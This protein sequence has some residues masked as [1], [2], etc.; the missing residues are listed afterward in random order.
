MVSPSLH[1][2]TRYLLAAGGAIN[3]D[4]V[5]AYLLYVEDDCL[6]LKHWTGTQFGDEETIAEDIRPGSTASYVVNGT[7]RTIV[8]ISSTN[9]I[10][11]WKYHEEDEEWV[12]DESIPA[13]TVH[14]NSHITAGV[15]AEQ[16]LR[17]AFQGPTGRL[18][19]LD[20]KWAQTALPANPIIGT[21]LFTVLW[22]GSFEVCYVSN[23]TRIHMVSNNSDKVMI[24]HALTENLKRMVILPNQSDELEVF[25]LTE[26]D[27][28]LR[29]A[30]EGGMGMSKEV[31]V[32]L[33]GRFIE[34]KV[35]GNVFSLAHRILNM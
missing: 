25:G 30:M 4:G 7:I 23:N 19:I 18:V 5:D 10:R 32:I 1:D 21:P 28:I 12:E 27:T 11:A 9:V 3:P 34:P 2:L 17:V 6:R 26:K 20:E 22:K 13:H 33:N 16:R 15:D 8:C 29:V 31:G 35:E 14:P 24:D